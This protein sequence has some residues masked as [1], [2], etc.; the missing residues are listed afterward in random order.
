LYTASRFISLATEH[1][2][3]IPDGLI[4]VVAQ[5]VEHFWQQEP[6]WQ[7]GRDPF[8]G[9]IRE[10]LAWK[11]AHEPPSKHPYYVGIIDE[12]MFA[13]AIALDLSH[14]MTEYGKAF[15]IGEEAKDYFRRIMAERVQWNGAG[16]LFQPDIWNKRPEQAYAGYYLPPKANKTDL[17]PKPVDCPGMDSSHSHRL[18]LWLLSGR[19]AMDVTRLQKGLT[20]QF[21]NR[22]LVP[23]QQVSVPLLNN[24][25]SGHN[26]FYRWRYQTH[27]E[28]GYAPYK[29]SGTFTLGWWS[30]LGGIPMQELYSKLTQTYP[31][32]PNIRQIYER[33]TT[34][35]RNPYVRYFYDNGIGKIIAEMA[36]DISGSIGVGNE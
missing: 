2:F 34:R 16:W 6:A 25:M 27:K 20:W 14:C 4:D 24:Y 22:V 35:E 7:W 13:I 12:E 19:Q 18:P 32:P 26:G 17:P 3:S 30:F 1:H 15:P 36:A 29:L 8:R 28:S 10:R 5:E 31:L 21:F 33:I 11:L 9:G 23:S